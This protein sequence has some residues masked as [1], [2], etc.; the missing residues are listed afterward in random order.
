MPAFA[1]TL[2]AQEIASLAGHVLHQFGHTQ[3]KITVEDEKNCAMSRML[4]WMTSSSILIS[5]P[6]PCGYLVRTIDASAIH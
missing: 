2:S 5:W 4:S 1:S 6:G 3:L